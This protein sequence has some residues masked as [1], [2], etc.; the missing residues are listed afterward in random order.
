MFNRIFKYILPITDNVIEIRLPIFHE[1]LDIQAQGDQIVIW[2]LV[3][4]DEEVFIKQFKIFATG[5]NIFCPDDY[6]YLKTVQMPDGLVWHVFE[7]NE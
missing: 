2:L 6:F 1:F 4:P 7:V 3:N 5:Q